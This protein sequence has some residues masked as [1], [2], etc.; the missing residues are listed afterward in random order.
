VRSDEISARRLRNSCLTGNTRA[1]PVDVVSRLGAVQAQDY[2]LTKW[3]IGERSRGLRDADIDRALRDGAIVRT[4]VLRPTWHLVAREDV[5]WLLALT[6]PGIQARNRRRYVELGLEPRLR[7]RCERVISA[8][9]EA[10]GPMTRDEIAA[11]L[12]ASGIN[13]SGQRMPHILMHCELESL[14]C[15]GGMRGKQHTYSLLNERVPDARPSD[16]HDAIAEL[17]RRYL[18]SHGPAT[19]A[20]LRWWSGL[21][22]SDIEE[23]LAGLG[24]EVRSETVD[25]LKFWMMSTDPTRAPRPPRGAH[26]LHAY[27]ELLVGYQRSRFFG[28]PHAER[29]R[30]AWGDQTLPR[31]MILSDGRVAGLWRRSVGSRK[32][33]IDF[34]PFDGRIDIR[35]LEAAAARMG[36]FSGLEPEL[37]PV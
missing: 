13:P 18:Q 23:A 10:A 31:G 9:I 26:L 5:R 16:P 4:H 7:A 22:S 24:D 21:T 27:D 35:A 11:A 15:S 3:S 17:T 32:V 14:I 25:G 20:D 34:L 37:H 19:V 1:Q 12:A 8:A 36:R 28:E 6:G 33:T 2:A 29:A 30:A